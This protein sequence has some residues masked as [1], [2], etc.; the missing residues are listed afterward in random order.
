MAIQEGQMRGVLAFVFGIVAVGLMA[1]SV[2]AVPKPSYRYFTD[3]DAFL[4]AAGHK[5]ALVTDHFTQYG[6]Q[7]FCTTITNDSDQPLVGDYLEVLSQ[8]ATLQPGSNALP[9]LCTEPANTGITATGFF[10]DW[11]LTFT[12]NQPT[13]AFGFRYAN[14]AV[15]GSLEFISPDGSTV[16]TISACCDGPHEGFFG[17]IAKTPFSRF[18]RI[19]VR[20]TGTFDITFL[21]QITISTEGWK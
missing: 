18:S 5:A 19:Y 20:N 4:K 8:V 15:T 14:A 9:S 17:V 13:T 6:S 10:T 21:R 16:T 3:E 1:P 2:N 11:I 12:V 7:I